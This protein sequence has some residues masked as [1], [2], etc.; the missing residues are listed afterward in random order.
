M[1]SADAENLTVPVNNGRTYH[2]VFFHPSVTAASAAITQDGPGDDGHIDAPL[3]S[4]HGL[5]LSNS[6]RPIRLGTAGVIDTTTAEVDSIVD[7]VTITL[8]DAIRFGQRAGDGLTL[9][10][11][12]IMVETDGIGL[13]VTGGK[14]PM[15]AMT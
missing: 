2:E 7:G 8:P 10:R 3:L 6:T 12:D 1:A 15:A 13:T 9:G 11:S 14:V 4:G 5:W